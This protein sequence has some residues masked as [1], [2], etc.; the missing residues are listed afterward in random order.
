MGAV[1]FISSGFPLA[2]RQK[3]LVVQGQPHA[4]EPLVLQVVN[5]GL[6]EEI[7]APLLVKALNLAVA[8]ALAEKEFLDGALGTAVAGLHH[9]AFLHLPA[10]EVHAAQNYFL[11]AGIHDFGAAGLQKAL[12]LS[13]RAT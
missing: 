4:V 1:I 13:Y 9:V 12:G 5:V 6:G 11:A 7:I 2:G 10:A 3:Q 8:L